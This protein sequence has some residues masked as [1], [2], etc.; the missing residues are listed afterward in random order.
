M[1][2]LEIS[3]SD[4]TAMPASASNVREKVMFCPVFTAS[5]STRIASS[6]TPRASACSR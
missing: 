3:R 5:G 4:S 2:G 6:G 1:Y